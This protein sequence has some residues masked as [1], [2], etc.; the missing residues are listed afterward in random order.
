MR[1][2]GGF[3]KTVGVEIELGCGIRVAGGS[4]RAGC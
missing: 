2:A 3:M 1:A 4:G